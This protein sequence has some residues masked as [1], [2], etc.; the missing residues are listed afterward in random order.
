M[1]SDEA[2]LLKNRNDRYS[3]SV[4]KNGKYTMLVT[5]T[6]GSRYQKVVKVK[7]IRKNSRKK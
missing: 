2:T 4:R 1:N 7:G 5:D 3:F 6:N